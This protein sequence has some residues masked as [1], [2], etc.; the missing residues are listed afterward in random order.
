MARYIPVSI[1]RIPF[2]SSLVAYARFFANFF[3]S[4]KIVFN[5][6][7]V[8]TDNIAIVGDLNS[9]AKEPP[10]DVLIN[11]GY[12][13]VEDL[14]SDPPPY[15]YVFSGQWGTLDYIFMSP[16]LSTKLVEFQTWFVN[17]DET[18]AIDY[19]I[20]FGRPQDIFDG[21]VPWRHSD[22]DPIIATFNLDKESG[23][24]K[25]EDRCYDH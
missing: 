18:P 23:K 11:A 7:G 25:K 20:D 19:N 8:E 13:S 14:N 5:S 9:Y 15:G 22:H 4:Q 2:C 12:I 1:C 6:T 3:W 10:I 17:A 24:S 16:E 21:S